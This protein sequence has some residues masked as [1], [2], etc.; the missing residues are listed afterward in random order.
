[1]LYRCVINSIWIESRV[2]NNKLIKAVILLTSFD[3]ADCTVHTIDL[4]SDRRQHLFF[5]LSLTCEFK[6]IFRFTKIGRKNAR[7]LTPRSMKCCVAIC[8]TVLFGIRCVTLQLRLARI[9]S[10]YSPNYQFAWL[11]SPSIESVLCVLAKLWLAEDKQRKQQ[12]SNTKHKTAIVT[13]NGILRD[14]HAFSALSLL[15]RM[16]SVVA[17]FLFYSI[18]QLAKYFAIAFVVVEQTGWSRY[19]CAQRTGSAI[20]TRSLPL[21]YRFGCRERTHFILFW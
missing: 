13:I 20:L 14:A 5:L 2:I 11:L 19:C 18:V 1:M 21:V 4:T 7:A 17:A 8:I 9:H 12:P 10:L 3:I 16:C 6:N 15:F